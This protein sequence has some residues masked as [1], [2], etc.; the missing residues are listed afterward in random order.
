MFI[1]VILIALLFIVL[2]IALPFIFKCIFKTQKYMGYSIGFCSSALTIAAIIGIITI[3]LFLFDLCFGN[4]F[5]L[6]I[7]VGNA[8]E[9][10][11][12]IFIFFSILVIY[13]VI[14]I[15]IFYYTKGISNPNQPYNSVFMFIAGYL[16]PPFALIYLLLI[17]NSLADQGNY[18]NGSWRYSLGLF[19]LGEFFFLLN[20]MQIA[21][22]IMLS[23]LHHRK[24]NKS[25]LGILLVCHFLP[26][27]SFLIGF[28][29]GDQY[30]SFIPNMVLNLI[31][32]G[33]GVFFYRKYASQ[34]YPKSE[35]LNPSDM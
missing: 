12:L 15:F 14:F 21:G 11:R 10:G 23:M 8:L 9:I 28:F 1:E 3:A 17:L 34:D 31:S 7:S 32:F 29:S 22:T 25:I 27:F 19:I 5:K 2:L 6:N 35:I 18:N 26:A 20:E 30:L 16:L 4:S 13:F 24:V 33:F